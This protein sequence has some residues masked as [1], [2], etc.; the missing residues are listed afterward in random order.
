MVLIVD[1]TNR[2]GSTIILLNAQRA[3]QKNNLQE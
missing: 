3:V 2:T 1:R